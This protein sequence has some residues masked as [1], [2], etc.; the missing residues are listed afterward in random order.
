MEKDKL[1]FIRG[2]VRPTVTWAV[3][4]AML[5]IGV[6]LAVKYATQGM[7]DKVVEDIVIMA[8]MIAAF[9]FGSRTS[10]STPPNPP[11]PPK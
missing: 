3:I 10:S 4:A 9:W 7:A 11:T 5:G 1:K 8:G 2:I 6:F